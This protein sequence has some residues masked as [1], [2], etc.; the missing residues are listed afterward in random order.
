MGSSS[1]SRYSYLLASNGGPVLPVKSRR[2]IRMD[3]LKSELRY[4]STEKSRQLI[5]LRME[6]ARRSSCPDLK[7]GIS[8]IDISGQKE[9]FPEE[10]MARR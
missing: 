10:F 2:V 3:K 8:E 7:T 9:K 1:L 4:L 5:F 6:S